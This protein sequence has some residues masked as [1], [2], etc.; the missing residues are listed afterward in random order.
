MFACT[1]DSSQMTFLPQS[2]RHFGI[3]HRHF[4]CGR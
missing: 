1:S 4:S 3:D 2:G